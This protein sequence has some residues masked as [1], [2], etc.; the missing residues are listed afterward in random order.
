MLLARTA[1]LKDQ[2]LIG[3][4]VGLKP[5][6]IS[7]EIVDPYPKWRVERKHPNICRNVEKGLFIPSGDDKDALTMLLCYPRAYLSGAHACSKV[8]YHGFTLT[9]PTI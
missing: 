1:I 2:L 6:P 5:S 3:K 4:F 7:D 8:G 9:T